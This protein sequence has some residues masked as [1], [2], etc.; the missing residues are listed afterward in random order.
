MIV[1]RTIVEARAAL[2]ALPRPLGLVPT[3]GALHEGHLALVTAAR[4]RCASVAASLFVNP[5]QFGAGEDFARYP[6]DEARD[7]ELFEKT[8]VG[9]VFAPPAAEMYPE[10]F[11]TTVHVGGPLT[12][13]YEA[14]QRPGHFDGVATVVVKLF[15]IVAP[16][17]AFF[18][19]KDAQQLALIRRA[20]RDLDLPVEVAGVA[21]VREPDGLAMSSRNAYLTPEQRAVAPDLYR[22]LLAGR[23][24]AGKLGG[25]AE[26]AIVAAAAV[27]AT[28]DRPA[29]DGES[30]VHEP[31]AQ[32]HH[33]HE[34]HLHGH[35]AH[36]PNGR[37]PAAPP[38]IHIEYLDVV[39]ADSF[40]RERR[41]TPRS[42]LIA[43]GRLGST[44]LLDNVSLLPVTP[45]AAAR[46]G[47]ARPST[48]ATV[49]PVT[50]ATAQGAYPAP[51]ATH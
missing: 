15:T 27:L 50:T 1:A 34:P 26:D 10:G 41:L 33:A 44:R 37:A 36:G 38:C 47:A 5:T 39:D 7:F 23:A 24:A 43:C 21:T 28:P 46:P 8:G 9:V 22:A 30:H 14:W 31:H 16:D 6:R 40:A 32:G 25:T 18:G 42:L 13:D 19:E 35:H 4:E 20:A 29:A 12:E 17:V 45:D 11:A 48:T 3:M 49:S 2:A 51:D